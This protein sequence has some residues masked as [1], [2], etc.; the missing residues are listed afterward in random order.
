MLILMSVLLIGYWTPHC[1]VSTRSRPDHAES[2]CPGQAVNLH[3]KAP[4][5]GQ[6][7]QR[8]AQAALPLTQLKEDLIRTEIIHLLN[9][10]SWGSYLADDK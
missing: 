1:A 4:W 5:K 3:N 6:G 2:F 8:L 7:Y 9:S 10:F